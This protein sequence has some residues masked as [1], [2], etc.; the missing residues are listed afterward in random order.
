MK[1]FNELFTFVSTFLISGQGRID[2]ACCDYTKEEQ[3][4]YLKEIHEK[5][6][7][8]I[9]MEATALASLCNKAGFKC[10]IV[11]V[12]LLNRLEGDQVDIPPDVYASYQERPQNL[13]CDYIRG[14]LAGNY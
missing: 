9:E 6:V 7:K 1:V 13:V 4:A 8:N 5:G 2:G 14:K 3:I 11:C 10:A 12:T